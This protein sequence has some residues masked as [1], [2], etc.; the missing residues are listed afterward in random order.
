MVTMYEFNSNKSFLKIIFLY[1]VTESDLLSS[2]AIFFP[3][4]VRVWVKSTIN[5]KVNKY[6]K[7]AYVREKKSYTPE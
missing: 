2:V 7:Q 4:L 5:K 1:R 6:A 3:P